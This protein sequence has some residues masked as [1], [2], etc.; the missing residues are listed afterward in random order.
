MSS[1]YHQFYLSIHVSIYLS[2]YLLS[3]RLSIYL[4]IN[5]P[6][7]ISISIN[8]FINLL[9][10]AC[11]GTG[12]GVGLVINNQSVKGLL[13]PEGGHLQVKRQL[14]DDDFQGTCPFHKDCIEGM[15]SS[16]AL[17]ARYNQQRN[18]RAM[19]ININNSTSSNDSN[20]NNNNNNDHD[21]VDN[22]DD[23]VN[24]KSHQEYTIKDLPLIPD[25]DIIW[26]TCAY[27]I[28]QLCVSLILIASPELIC[29]GMILLIV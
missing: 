3:F 15:C 13:H 20:N 18:S 6:I 19:N 25:D 22:D 29:I 8:Q 10:Y 2:I 24:N 17:V 9:I 4:L 26:D 23:A 14:H 11:L 28:A 21:V 1:S 27:Y 12:V 5:L 16:G 7:H